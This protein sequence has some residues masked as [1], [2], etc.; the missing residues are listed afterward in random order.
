MDQ[1]A[2]LWEGG[3]EHGA[4]FNVDVLEGQALFEAS[5]DIAAIS[6]PI[7]AWRSLTRSG[8]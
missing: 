4:P 8:L 2:F 6:F 3:G 5:L 7:V 1:A